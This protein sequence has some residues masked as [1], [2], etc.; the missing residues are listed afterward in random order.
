MSPRFHSRDDPLQFPSI[1]NIST[2]TTSSPT[3]AQ[4]GRLALSLHL[5]RREP[6]DVAAA[7]GVAALGESLLASEAVFLLPLLALGVRACAPFAPGP[8]FGGPVFDGNAL[9]DVVVAAL[10][11]FARVLAFAFWRAVKVSLRDIERDKRNK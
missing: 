9:E 5:G 10:V 6:S 1:K 2:C 7:H 4:P 8:V 3:L 11:H